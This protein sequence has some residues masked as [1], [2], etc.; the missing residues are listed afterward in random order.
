M[1]RIPFPEQSAAI[2]Y[3]DTIYNFQTI[4]IDL[5]AGGGGI[6]IMQGLGSDR[7]SRVKNYT[8][9]LQGVRFGDII[10]RGEDYSGQRMRVNA[11]SYAGQDLARMITEKELIFSE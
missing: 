4:S 9:R 3:L 1:T 10:D 6:G 2:D 5:G 11:K 7:Y 8:K